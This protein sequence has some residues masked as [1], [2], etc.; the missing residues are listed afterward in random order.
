M[1]GTKTPFTSVTIAGATAALVAF[2]SAKAGVPMDQVSATDIA[3]TAL[4]LGAYIATWIGRLRA[5][6]QIQ[7]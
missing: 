5:K 4:A 2:L 6:K 1:N 3:E 7:L